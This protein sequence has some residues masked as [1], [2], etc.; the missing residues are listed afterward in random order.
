MVEV[1]DKSMG[2]M[3]G[4]VVFKFMTKIMEVKLSLLLCEGNSD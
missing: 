1:E 4:R 3:Y 2:K